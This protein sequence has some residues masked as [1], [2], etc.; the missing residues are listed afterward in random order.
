MSSTGILPGLTSSDADQF[1]AALKK[2]V[3]SR[4]LP[5]YKMMAYHLGWV[6]QNGEPEPVVMQDRSHGHLVLSIANALGADIEAAMPYAV[7][8]EMLYNFLLVHEDVQNANTERNNRPTIWWSWGPAQA[9]NAGDGIHAMARISIFEQRNAS[10]PASDP[11]NISLALESLDTATL[12]VCEGEYLDISYQER[13]AVSVEEIVSVAR[14]HGAL[15]GLSAKLGGIAATANDDVLDALYKF[16]TAV[17]AAQ[18]LN[19]DL[20]ALWPD[21]GAERNEVQRGRLQSKKKSIA[22]AHAIENGTPTTRRRLGEIFMKRVLDPSDL[23]EVTGILAETDSKSFA[24][25]RVKELIG[26]ATEALNSMKIP[27]PQKE[28]LIESSKLIAG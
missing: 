7:A 8:V 17:G 19:I 13:A 27:A 23:D 6:D 28:S 20:K 15:F 25:G 12:E 11:R 22:T 21:E 2:F 4:E 18:N 24:E 1:E 5:L 16:G 26:E 9:I 3:D 14:K 10:G